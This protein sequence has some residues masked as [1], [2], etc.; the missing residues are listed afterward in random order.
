MAIIKSKSVE[1]SWG[2]NMGG[3]ARIWKV[4]CSNSPGP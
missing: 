3:L 4:R 2:V 1:K